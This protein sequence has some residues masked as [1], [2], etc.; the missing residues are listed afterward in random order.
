MKIICEGDAPDGEPPRELEILQGFGDFDDTSRPSARADGDSMCYIYFTSGSTGEPKAIAGRFKAIG[1][2]VRWETDVLGLAAGVRVSQLTTP[3]FDAYMR[4]VFTPLAVGGAVCIPPSYATAWNPPA[5]VRCLAESGVSVL[6]CVPGVLRGL[7][8]AA[9]PGALPSLRYVLSAG[10]ALF[11][12]DVKRWY[13]VFGDGARLVNLYG[14]SETTM[15]KFFHFVRREDAEGERV[16]VGRPMPD[17]EGIIVEDGR[18]CPPGI[19]GEILIRS[20]FAALGYFERPEMTRESFV[21]DTF[22][23]GASG[24]VYRTGDLGRILEDGSLDLAGRG[25]RQVKLGGVRTE[26]G[27][28]ESLILASG[29]VEEAAVVDLED[30]R[31]EKHLHAYLVAGEG[32]DLES[33]RGA[34]ADR[35]HPVAVPTGFTVVEKLP[36]TITGKVDRR[37]LP[38]PVTSQPGERAA[39]GGGVEGLLVEIWR[40]LFKTDAVS[41]DDDFFGL[42]G[43][44]LRAT[45]A[46][47]RLAQYGIVMP[48]RAVFEHPV[49]RDLAAHIESLG[50]KGASL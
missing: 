50:R 7:L 15:T 19:V 4:D 29:E 39:L 32:I 22:G 3:S 21:P 48:L 17:T 1:H 25:D 30:G 27:E 8:R 16:P 24:V 42:G 12:S 38:P 49:L 46:V 40:V 31:G 45:M 34:L 35:L 43:D 47:A 2:F 44:S 18:V 6:H 5:L 11:P 36:R 41:P 37:A 13:D 14:P 33:L 9:E 20:P 26:L 23:G 28:V 10:D